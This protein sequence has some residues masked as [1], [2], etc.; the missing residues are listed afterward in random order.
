MLSHRQSRDPGINVLNPTIPGLKISHGIGFPIH[1]TLW[2]VCPVLSAQ[3]A[4]GSYT[5]PASQ[6]ACVRECVCA[7]VRVCEEKVT[8][9]DRLCESSSRSSTLLGKW[10]EPLPL[11]SSIYEGKNRDIW[12]NFLIY[13][14]ILYFQIQNIFT[15][16]SINL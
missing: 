6:R 3:C 9:N 1:A 13:L 7:S 5:P 8:V 16:S 10:K 14:T 11:E 2:L 15:L 12:I 4:Y